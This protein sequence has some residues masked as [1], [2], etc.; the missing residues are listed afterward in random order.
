MPM[1]PHSSGSL[2][3]LYPSAANLWNMFL[4]LLLVL[5]QLPFL[6]SIPF[7]VVFPVGGVLVGVVIFWG[8][9]WCVWSMVYFL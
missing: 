8:V 2:C 9:N 1:S 4:H 7:W 6:V 5:L 3:E